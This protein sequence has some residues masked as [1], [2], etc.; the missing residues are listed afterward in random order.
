MGQNLKLMHSIPGTGYGNVKDNSIGEYDKFEDWVF[1]NPQTNNQFNY[2]DKYNLLPEEKYG[3]RNEALEII[4]SFIIHSP[5]SVYCH[6]DYSPENIFN[7]EPMTV[8]DPVPIFNT[9]YF[10][11]SKS[12]VQI[13]AHYP[14]QEAINQLIQGYFS[15]NNQAVDS[16]VLKAFVLFIAY[17]KFSYWH[18]TN[19]IQPMENVKNYLENNK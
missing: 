16:K 2:I 17:T 3:S 18:K 1:K 15:D 13:L 8:F 5:Q 19:R 9:P 6:G 14:S 11:I 7:T 4:F 12:I 10:D